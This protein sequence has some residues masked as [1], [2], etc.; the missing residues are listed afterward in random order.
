[1]A[2]LSG[3]EICLLAVIFVIF[4]SLLA[5][6]FVIFESIALATVSSS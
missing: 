3:K 2:A 6:I 1:M 5:A 4:E